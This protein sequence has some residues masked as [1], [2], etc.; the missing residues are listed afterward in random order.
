MLEIS[1]EKLAGLVRGACSGGMCSRYPRSGYA[2]LTMVTTPLLSA[3][4]IDCSHQI[5]D[6]AVDTLFHLI[7]IH[8]R[9]KGSY[10]MKWA[11]LSLV[12]L[13]V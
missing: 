10:E 2:M 4:E 9:I 8:W 11:V 7:K 13:V 5:V 6:T 1:V 12:V 3:T